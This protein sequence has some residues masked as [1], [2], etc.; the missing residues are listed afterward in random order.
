LLQNGHS[1]KK[2]IVPEDDADS[3]C[4]VGFFGVVQG[5]FA[6]GEA[7]QLE[8]QP[9]LEAW[10]SLELLLVKNRLGKRRKLSGKAGSL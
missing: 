5:N 7:T 1:C 9:A 3:P 10:K 4:I 2:P 8:T 6:R